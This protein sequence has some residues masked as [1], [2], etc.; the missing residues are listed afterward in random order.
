MPD[1]YIFFWFGKPRK[2]W[3]KLNKNSVVFN[4][5]DNSRNRFAVVEF[6]GIFLPG[7]Q[8]FPSGQVDEA[9]FAKA[10]EEQKQKAR[11]DRASKVKTGKK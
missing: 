2:I 5:S 8:Q 3:R 6:G 9:G 7:A 1:F 11:S 4:A 10:M